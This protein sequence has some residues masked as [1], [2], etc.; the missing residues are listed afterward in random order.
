MIPLHHHQR[1]SKHQNGLGCLL[2][3]LPAYSELLGAAGAP[4]PPAPM[5]AAFAGLL[6]GTQRAGT[7]FLPLDL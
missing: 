2:A 4:Q 6:P 1:Y 3:S 5:G 7:R